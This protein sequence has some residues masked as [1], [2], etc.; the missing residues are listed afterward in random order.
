MTRLIAASWPK[1]GLPE[2]VDAALQRTA[3][4]RRSLDID[5]PDYRSG[6]KTGA[7]MTMASPLS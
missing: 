2:V 5:E 1:P 4:G 3:P 6:F 7:A